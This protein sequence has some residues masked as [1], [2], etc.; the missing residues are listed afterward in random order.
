VYNEKLAFAILVKLNEEFPRKAQLDELRQ[1]L[2]DFSSVPE[3]EWLIAVDA[4]IKL[5]RAQASIVRHGM[6]DVP[7]VIANIEITDEGREFLE[8]ARHVS[9]GESGDLDDLLPIFAKRQFEK[10]IVTL[11]ASA[12]GSTP[13]S[14]L[15][16]DLDHFKSVNDSFNHLVGDE[17]LIETAKALRAVC[18]KKGRCYRWG[19]EEFAVL[20]PN[21]SLDE[22]RVLAERVRQAIPQAKFKKYPHEVTASIGV[23]TYPETSSMDD[24]LSDA[25]NAMLAAKEAG[26][27]QVCL[28]KRASQPI[29]TSGTPETRISAA[30]ISKRVDAARIIATIEQGLAANFLIDVQNDSDDEVTVKEVE[31]LSENDIRLTQ[32]ARQPEK[33]LWRFPPRA[34]LPIGWR[35]QPDPAGALIKMNSHRGAIF[36]TE[37]KI[38]LSVEVLGRPKRCECKLWVQVDA[39]NKKITQLAG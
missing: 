33:H 19:G 39:F 5:G 28:S 21:Y 29:T 38:I 15:F 10:D 12:N 26:R 24:L 2:S 9:N 36:D 32:P 27:N 16:T 20:L 25:D 7:G 3:E 34:K 14:L 8:R 23:A 13:L 31:L 17:V 4:L 30:E 11:A 1:A 6:S 37:L 35:A 18:D 22:A